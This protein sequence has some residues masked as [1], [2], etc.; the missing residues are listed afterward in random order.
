MYYVVTGQGF[1]SPLLMELKQN[2][3]VTVLTQEELAASSIRIG[4]QDKM[5]VPIE[6]SLQVVMDKLDDPEKKD[7]ITVLKDKYACR[8]LL[9][10][11]YPSFYF[12][13]V[14]LN[15][16]ADFKVAP[17][18]KYFVKPLRGFFNT[19]VKEFSSRTD[20][21]K[22]QASLKADIEAKA[23]YF[24]ED[25]LSSTELLVEEYIKGIEFEIDMYYDS[26]GEPVIIN[27]ISHPMPKNKAYFFVLN[28]VSQELF[29]KYEKKL[30]QIFKKLNEQ[31]QI[32]DM[33]IHAEFKLT[34]GEFVPIEF[35]PMRYGGW[36]LGE[37]A[38]YTFGFSPV[39]AFFNNERPNWQQI[40]A[41]RQ[42]KILAHVLGYNGTKVDLKT[43]KP[44]HAKFKKF[45][46]GK[47]LGYNELDYKKN[48]VFAIAYAEID[49]AKVPEILALEFN[50][51]FS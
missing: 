42:G 9:K 28:Y 36:G 32:K 46:G 3:N 47:L 1:I 30:V 19:G 43:Q 8:Q 24:S 22:L 48:P 13:R 12:D 14:D 6:A 23:Q 29:N 33:P 41:E 31:L 17:G 38:G 51:Y 50:E 27:I 2:K 5:Y 26:A 18:K 49:E 39:L 40:W 20:M 10:E 4:K 21:T 34:G 45:L 7:K 11:M 37:L 25:V 15:D 44:N 35:N 16:L